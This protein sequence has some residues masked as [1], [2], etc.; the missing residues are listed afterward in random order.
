M[1]TIYV[2]MSQGNSLFRYASQSNLPMNCTEPSSVLLWLG[3]P[4]GSKLKSGKPFVVSF[5]MDIE[6]ASGHR[7]TAIALHDGMVVSLQNLSDSD[8]GLIYKVSY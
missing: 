4:S 7:F 2:Y 5:M 3:P 8:L 6:H 1:T